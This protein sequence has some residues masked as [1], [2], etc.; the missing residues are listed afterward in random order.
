MKEKVVLK[1][2]KKLSKKKVLEDKNCEVIVKIPSFEEGQAESLYETSHNSASQE[3]QGKTG[4]GG[5]TYGHDAKEVLELSLPSLTFFDAVD[6]K[7]SVISEIELPPR[8]TPQIFISHIKPKF[9]ISGEITTRRE[10]KSKI[11]LPD[12]ALITEAILKIKLKLTF[13]PPEEISQKAINSGI[14]LPERLDLKYLNAIDIPNFLFLQRSTVM[15]KEISLKVPVRVS[16]LE[17]S[18]SVD[19]IGDLDFEDPFEKIFGSTIKLVSERPIVIFAERPENENLE[20]IEFLKRIL[21]EVYRIRIGGLPSPA[22]VSTR[23]EEIKDETRAGKSI[24]VIDVDRVEPKEK[25]RVLQDKLKELYSQNFGFLAFYGSGGNLDKIRDLWEFKLVVREKTFSKFE[26]LPGF[27]DIKVPE[28]KDL[29]FKLVNLFWGQMKRELPAGIE[30]DRYAVTLENEFYGKIER[31]ANYVKIKKN[32]KWIRVPT[33]L[34]VE[35]S[36]E[37]TILHYAL[38]GFIIEFIHREL[39]VPIEKI[40]TEKEFG[41]IKIDV[42]V[43]DEKLGQVAIEIETLYGTCIPIIKLRKTAESR[44]E[45]G[46]RTWIVIPNPQLMIY[47][48]DVLTLREYLRKKYGNSVEF[49][50][51]NIENNK[52]ISIKEFIEKIREGTNRSLK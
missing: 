10:I 45:R 15:S 39:D 38:K 42:F 33:G 24:Y 4:L 47:L 19:S 17:Q 9:M 3:I 2:R 40:S 48:K 20:Y 26:K 34:I 23:F 28:D 5:N 13:K 49:Y 11:E 21:R 1:F 8:E 12:T 27:I 43:N 51:L 29:L 50:T 32:E 16:L 52:L 37:E 31:Y 44:A 6:V 22:H 41:D 46:L 7:N 18:A 36:E 14:I 30:L 35:P 25:D